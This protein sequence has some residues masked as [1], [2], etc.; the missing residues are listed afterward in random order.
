MYYLIT[1]QVHVRMYVRYSSIITLKKLVCAITR[2][3]HEQQKYCGVFASAREIDDVSTARRVLKK[4]LASLN[5]LVHST[6]G[7][8]SSIV[9]THVNEQQRTYVP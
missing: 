6:R 4:L 9:Q 5:K 7:V 3:L 8:C 2:A 1:S